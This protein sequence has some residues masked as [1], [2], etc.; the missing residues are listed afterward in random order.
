MYRVS[1]MLEFAVIHP[2]PAV[3]NVL[4]GPIIITWLS[5]NMVSPVIIWYIM[6]HHHHC[7][8]IVQT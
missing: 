8:A 2:K 3:V 1:T 6:L 4:L 7:L 5:A